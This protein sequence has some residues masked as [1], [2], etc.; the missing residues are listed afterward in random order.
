MGSLVFGVQSMAVEKSMAVN[1]S[2]K[3]ILVQSTAVEQSMGVNKSEKYFV[4]GVKWSCEDCGNE[5]VLERK[6]YSMKVFVV[7][8]MTLMTVAVGKVAMMMMMMAVKVAMGVISVGVE[9]HDV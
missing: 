6:R 2:E 9:V 3:S 5:K 4:V 7:V 8:A 1:K